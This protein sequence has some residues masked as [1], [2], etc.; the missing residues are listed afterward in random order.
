MIVRRLVDDQRS[1]L[2]YLKPCYNNYWP[3]SDFAPLS[4]SSSEWYYYAP[5]VLCLKCMSA[6]IRS[7][8][9]I[10]TNTHVLVMRTKKCHK[11]ITPGGFHRRQCYEKKFAAVFYFIFMFSISAHEKHAQGA[12]LEVCHNDT[13]ELSNIIIYYIRYIPICTD[14]RRNRV[15]TRR[16]QESV[17]ICVDKLLF[18]IVLVVVQKTISRY[19]SILVWVL[20]CSHNVAHAHSDE[21]DV[22]ATT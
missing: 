17:L 14:Q 9:K 12:L 16:L 6:T 19:R 3:V 22:A 7:F 11:T 4:G 20:V 21:L 8:D 13:I 1:S 15:R 10:H 5:A 2:L 18:I